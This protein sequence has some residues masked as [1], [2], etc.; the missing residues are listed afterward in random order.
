MLCKK[1][2]QT[3]WHESKH[4]LLTHVSVYLKSGQAQLNSL[5]SLSQG[6]NQGFYQAGI[7]SG[8]SRE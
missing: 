6:K 8:R 7:L 4:P 1:L 2:L 3:L 5:M